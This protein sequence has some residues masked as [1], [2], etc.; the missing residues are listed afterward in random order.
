MGRCILRKFFRYFR[1]IEVRF[2]EI[3]EGE[4]IL[5]FRIGFLFI[6]SFYEVFKFRN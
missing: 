5:D 3:V 1:G 6:C 4:V 2:F